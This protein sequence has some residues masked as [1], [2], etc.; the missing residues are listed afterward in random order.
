MINIATIAN[1]GQCFRFN[2]IKNGIYELVAFGKVIQ[3][4]NI[5][6]QTLFMWNL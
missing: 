1:S 2:Y 6:D 3:V 4:S 5:D